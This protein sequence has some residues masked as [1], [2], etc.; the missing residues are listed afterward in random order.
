MDCCDRRQIAGAWLAILASVAASSVLHGQTDIIRREQKISENEGNFDGDLDLSDSF[1]WSLASIGDL[2]NDGIAELAV[3]APQDDD[4]GSQ[5][6]A[7]W[8]LFLLSDGTVRR[9]A[10]ISSVSGGFVGPLDTNDHFGYGV[11]P[12]GDLTEAARDANGAP[13]LGAPL[14]RSRPR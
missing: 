1:A 8:I 13:H 9:E 2:D 11:A 6:G 10:K 4:G 14:A 7:V 5:H 3:A 12:L